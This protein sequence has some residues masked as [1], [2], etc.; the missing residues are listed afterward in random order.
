MVQFSGYLDA[1][2]L[3][4]ENMYSNPTFD[5]NVTETLVLK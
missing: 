2:F 4:A 5:S 1:I 3:I